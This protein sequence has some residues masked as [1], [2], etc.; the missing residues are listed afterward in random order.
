LS[1]ILSGAFFALDILLICLSF[2]A[3]L[4]VGNLKS[5]YAAGLGFI[6]IGTI[7]N[8]V[9]LSLYSQRT[10][11]ISQPQTDPFPIYVLMSSAIVSL[12]AAHHITQGLFT[13]VIAAISIAT[14]LTGML[15]LL[16]GL[17]KRA[18]LISFLP[19]PVIAGFFA[20]GGWLLFSG[21]LTMLTNLPVTQASLLN[22]F[23]PMMLLEWLPA[24]G[25][26]ILLSLCVNYSRSIYPIF[27]IL[28]AAILLF[29]AITI[30]LLGIPIATLHAD[31]L[32]LNEASKVS[33]SSYFSYFSFG[34]I[35]WP[36]IIHEFMAILLIVFFSVVGILIK[37]S[38]LD[39][40]LKTETDLSRE[41]RITGA[42]NILSGLFGGLV[43]YVSMNNTLLNSQFQQTKDTSPYV[44]GLFAGL[45]CLILFL[46]GLNL[47]G[48]LPR[49]IPGGM[50]MFFGISYIKK[51]VYDT[52]KQIEWHEYIIILIILGIVIKYG[53][54]QG[55]LA[56]IVIST[57]FFVVTYSRMSVIRYIITGES[58][59]SNKQREPSTKKWLLDHGNYLLYIKLQNYIF[60]GNALTLWKELKHRLILTKH[61]IHYV[62]F[63]FHAVVGIDSSAIT[64][65]IKMQQLAE[66]E[67]INLIFI[68]MDNARY[69]I[70]KKYGLLKEG[71]S[72]IKVFTSYDDAMQWCEEDYLIKNQLISRTRI[73]LEDRLNELYGTSNT[74][75]I[76]QYFERIVIKKGEYLF[77]KNDPAGPLYY[78]ESGYLTI[79]WE[80]HEYQ[81][82]RL[83]AIGPGNTIG[84]IGFYLQQPRS[85]TVIADE[86]CVLQMLSDENRVRMYEEDSQ[87]MVYFDK[88]IVS[89]LAER[90]VH[91]NK[92]IRTYAHRR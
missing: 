11:T 40:L 14:L 17:F 86:D 58:I 27:S 42:A 30:G 22:F 9:I 35:Y 44:V 50:L 5:Y 25:Y 51:W 69:H 47:I 74:S 13:T 19:Y 89:I 4:Y 88:Y 53:I 75:R 64:L 16:I 15:F 90:I 78:V 31:N 26:A 52:Y 85:A 49:F 84:E 59:S 54:F 28:I 1:Y 21:S 70:L 83:R 57:T 3:L 45:F 65:F 38:G 68:E 79:L 2:A 66:K 80:T 37:L 7:I 6:L 77:H 41:L 39:I 20:G 33:M 32:L 73:P 81:P 76:T 56:G 92:Q 60:F 12:F 62:I 8:V 36:A 10:T 67:K 34:L 29:Y 91:T 61:T 55:V 46:Y 82:K 48:Y 71:I 87:L 72:T 18:D 24:F 43:G 23:E 63:D